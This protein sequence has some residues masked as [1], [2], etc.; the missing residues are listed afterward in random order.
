LSG[1]DLILATI[2]AY[3]IEMRLCEIG[4]PVCANT[5]GITQR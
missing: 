5:G 3:E 4:R 1:K 2:I